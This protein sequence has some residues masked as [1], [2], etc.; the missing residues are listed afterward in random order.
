MADKRKIKGLDV[1]ADMRAGM[2]AAELM[3][4][5]RLSTRGLQFILRQLSDAANANPGQF[6][7]RSEQDQHAEDT[8]GIR[9]LTRSDMMCP[10]RLQDEKNPKNQGTVR[11]ISPKGL[12]TKGFETKLGQVR[13]LVICADE[14]FEMDRFAFEAVCRWVKTDPSDG[15]CVA[16]F[17]ISKISETS[18]KRL[19]ELKDLIDYMF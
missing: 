6:Y 8:S 18:A 10:L 2:A 3:E 11:D 13:A 14:F 17:E 19:L 12:G 7:G 9:I 1:L 16:G 5:Y 4:K 15:E